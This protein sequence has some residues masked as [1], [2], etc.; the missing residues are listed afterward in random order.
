MDVAKIPM[1][2][3]LVLAAIDILERQILVIIGILFPREAQN[4]SN[5]K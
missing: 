4:V 3:N 1:F 5:V 2:I